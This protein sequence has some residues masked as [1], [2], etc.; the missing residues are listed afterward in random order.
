MAKTLAK[1]ASPLGRR[2]SRSRGL[3]SIARFDCRILGE[4]AGTRILR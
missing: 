1:L 4:A 2:D 3:R